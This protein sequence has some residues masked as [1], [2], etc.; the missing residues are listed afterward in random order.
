MLFLQTRE[1]KVEDNVG[2][3]VTDKIIDKLKGDTWFIG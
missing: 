1:F 3:K 2:N